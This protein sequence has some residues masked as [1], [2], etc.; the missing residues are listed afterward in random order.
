MGRFSIGSDIMRG[1][2]KGEKGVVKDLV[3]VGQNPC[4]F[5]PK[6]SL[7]ASSCGRWLG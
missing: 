4:G 6:T 7:R 2:Y 1:Y 3:T 5:N